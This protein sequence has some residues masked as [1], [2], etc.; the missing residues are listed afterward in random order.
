MSARAVISMQGTHGGVG[1][2]GGGGR[3]EQG[4]TELADE[5]SKCVTKSITSPHS[6]G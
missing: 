2:E 5:D 3:A 6:P 4:Q 1:G